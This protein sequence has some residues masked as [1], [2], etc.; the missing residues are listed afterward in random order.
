MNPFHNNVIQSRVYNTF[1]L[2]LDMSQ[3]YTDQ[4]QSQQIAQLQRVAGMRSG[5]YTGPRRQ[6]FKPSMSRSTGNYGATRDKS[7]TEIKG[8]DNNID[9]DL[10]VPAPIT[11][12]TDLGT[13]P[14]AYQRIGRKINLKSVQVRG[15][16]DLQTN[17]AALGPVYYRML[18]VYDKQAN[19]SAFLP[20]DFFGSQ[21]K[22][23]TVV[24]ST[25]LQFIL[26]M[27]LDNRDRYEI[28]M[29]KL[30]TVSVTVNTN[31]I[32]TANTVIPSQDSDLI[33]E[34]FRKL[35]RRDVAFKTDSV[36]PAGSSIQSG[37]LV[38]F[39]V[40]SATNSLSFRG[41]I[42]LRYYDN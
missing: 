39:I 9:L 28:I 13:G 15:V 4:R 12:L 29:D 32:S 11:Y 8:V 21:D 42:R 7:M 24:N 36:G 41:S 34:E 31:G 33:V 26:P 14:G 17:A 5:G 30:G 2:N 22:L 18:I 25:D 6:S 20:T 10:A 38:F 35:K 40:P 27:N 23:G 19:G 3:R 1:Y 16:F 37:S